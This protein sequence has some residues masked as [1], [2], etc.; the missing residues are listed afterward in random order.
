MK[1]C[2][3]SWNR[4]SFLYDLTSGFS[5]FWPFG[6]ICLLASFILAFFIINSVFNLMLFYMSPDLFYLI[7]CCMCIIYSK[8]LPEERSKYMAFEL[9]TFS[10]SLRVVVFYFFLFSFYNFLTLRLKC[11]SLFLAYLICYQFLKFILSLALI[12]LGQF[13]DLGKVKS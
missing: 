7:L 1:E 3:L 5:F 12:N 10:I 4:F 8:V 9:L 2:D 6:E 13:L 11:S